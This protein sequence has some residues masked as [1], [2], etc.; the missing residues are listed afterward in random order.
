MDAI[1]QIGRE[2][3]EHQK[4]LIRD[5]ATDI[6]LSLVMFILSMSFEMQSCC[7]PKSFRIHKEIV[8]WLK[9]ILGCLYSLALR[10]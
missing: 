6:G 8:Q 4:K 2:M 10:S 7:F 5:R 3:M 1:F 9:F